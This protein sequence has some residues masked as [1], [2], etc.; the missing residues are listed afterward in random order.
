MKANLVFIREYRKPLRIKVNAAE[1]LMLNQVRE[2]EDRGL[3]LHL[4][5][6][7]DHAAVQGGLERI[8]DPSGRV[9]FLAGA[10]RA[11]DDAGVL[12]L[13]LEAL[14]D[15]AS[16]KA[17]AGAFALGTNR[18]DWTGLSAARLERLLTVLVDVFTDSHERASAL[19]ALLH[20]PS[21]RSLLEGQAEDLPGVLRRDLD[22]LL[23]VYEVVMEG[24]E[25]RFGR[26]ALSRGAA[27]LLTAPDEIL[28][29]YPE[30]VRLRL[31]QSAVREM[32][33]KEEADRAAGVLLQ[34]LP[35]DGKAFEE[36]TL[37]R[38]GELLRNHAD[39]RARW[40]LEQ[41]RKA[42]PNCRQA[43]ELLRAMR[44]PRLGRLVLGWPEDWKE[45][46][47]KGSGRLE[48]RTLQRAYWLDHGHRVW[49]RIG[50]ASDTEAFDLE[51]ALQDSLSIPGIATVLVRGRDGEGRPWLAMPARGAPAEKS[52]TEGP[53]STE[54]AL[55]LAARG[56]G[57]LVALSL[58]GW[59]LPEARLRRFLLDG[60]TDLLLADLTGVEALAEGQERDPEVHRSSAFGLC[61]DLLRG[62]GGELPP[63]LERRLFN[64]RG[65]VRDLLRSVEM[66]R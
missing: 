45:R 64:R 51:A 32:G 31:L 12:L 60:R 53:P 57:V 35:H 13:Y 40:H 23:A 5:S 42:Q 8:S 24:K 20:T 4:L 7:V 65:S 17:A 19:F 11:T 59:K 52:L 14:R 58:L 38:V 48:G 22:P 41:L 2:P 43:R 26:A 54:E 66:A 3:C 33:N 25:N 49:I 37:A 9:R 21:F 16:R 27:S 39:A 34:S 1:D 29:G 56:L 46:G 28:L 61:R 10:V 30:P 15:S 36:L 63:D 6:K 62:R 50:K 47:G 44:A 55:A 18:I